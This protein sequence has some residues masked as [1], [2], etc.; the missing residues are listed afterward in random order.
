MRIRFIALSSDY[1]EIQIATDWFP[2]L[3]DF[4]PAT[5]LPI[6]ASPSLPPLFS[7]SSILDVVFPGCLASRCPEGPDWLLWYWSDFLQLPM[8]APGASVQLPESASVLESEGLVEKLK[9][10]Y[11]TPMYR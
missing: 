2:P 5:S 1:F 10:I 11:G 6:G 3:L 7:Q 4:F 8:G 9:N